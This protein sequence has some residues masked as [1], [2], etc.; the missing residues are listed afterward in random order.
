MKGKIE[1]INPDGLSK[2]LAFTQV[3]TTQGKGK[4]MYIGGQD[5]VH[6]DGSIVGKGDI[7]SLVDAKAYI[8]KINAVQD[9]SY[10]SVSLIQ[11]NETIGL[12]TL[13]K[14]DYLDLKDIGF[15][16]LPSFLRERLR[17]RSYRSSHALLS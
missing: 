15:A 1:Y 14:R 10:W 7:N 8:Q 6:A 4:T 13:I 5:A 16:F 3:V 12:I 17:L 2:N 9:I 11:S